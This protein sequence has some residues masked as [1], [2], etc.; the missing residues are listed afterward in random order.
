MA[1]F[2]LGMNLNLSVA[3]VSVVATLGLLIPRADSSPA[4]VRRLLWP[5]LGFTLG[6]GATSL[7][8]F[9]A[10]PAVALCAAASAAL[11]LALIRLRG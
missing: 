7:Y 2:D 5:V 6:I 8:F 9:F 3:I 11:V 10:L 1:D 4:L